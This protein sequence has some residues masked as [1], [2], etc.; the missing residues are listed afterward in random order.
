MGTIKIKKNNTAIPI[1]IIKVATALLILYFSSFSINGSNRKLKTIASKTGKRALK[2]L[3][4]KLINPKWLTIITN[5]PT[6][7]EKIR[8][9][10]NFR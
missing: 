1:Y 4:N 3:N 10:I 5:T 2:T 8:I 6:R 9:I 7:I